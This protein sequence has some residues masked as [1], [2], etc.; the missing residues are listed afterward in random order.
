MEVPSTK[1]MA[2]R[3]AIS[4]ASMRDVSRGME[5]AKQALAQQVSQV[6]NKASQPKPGRQAPED[7]SK[8]ITLQQHLL[9]QELMAK[10]PR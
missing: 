8:Q 4:G 10:M 9:R 7:Q 1:E 5:L 2:R 6:S 3:A